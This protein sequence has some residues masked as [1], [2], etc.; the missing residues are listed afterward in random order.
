ALLLLGGIPDFYDRFGYVDVLD[1]AQH[2][3][4]RPR[5]MAE[6]A[7]ACSVRPVALADAPV[8]L[9]LYQRHYGPYRG[10]FDWTPAQ[11]AHKLALRMPDNP[12]LLA[13]EPDGRP[14]G[15]LI[16]PW[17]PEGVS[18]GEIAADHWPAL[19]ALLQQHACPQPP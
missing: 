9:A 2:A 1:I 10:S 7:S 11:V 14:C 8:V 16:P 19:L 18:S 4:E 15:Y 17:S 13:V 3:V 12:P 6:P 5:I